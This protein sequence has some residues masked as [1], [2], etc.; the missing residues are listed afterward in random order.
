[1]TCRGKWQAGGRLTYSPEKTRGTQ[2]DSFFVE[3][4]ISSIKD[5]GIPGNQFYIRETNCYEDFSD[6]GFVEMALRTGAVLENLGALVA[7]LPPDRVLW[8]DVPDGVWYNRIPYLWP[9]NAPDSCLLNIAKFKSHSMGMTLSAK[10]IQG[11]NAARYIQHCAALTST[12]TVDPAHIQPGAAGSIEANYQ[13]HLHQGFPRWDTPGSGQSGGLWMETWATRCLDNH[14][15][16]KPWINI[17]EGVYGREG[18]FLQGPSADGYGIDVM[19]NL[20]IFGKNPFHAD[21]IGTWLAGHEPG[22]FGLFHMARERGFSKFLNPADVPLYEW[23]DDGTA[24]LSPLSSFARTPIRT[25]YLSRAGE[26]T[27]HLVNEPYEYPTDVTPDRPDAPAAFVL[28]Q[29]YPNPFNPSTSIQYQIPRGANVRLEVFDLCGQVV[30]RLVDGWVPAGRHLAV[31]HTARQ[32]SGTYF[33]NLTTA[34]YSA[35]KFMVVLK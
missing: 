6:G 28:S 23:N 12:L 33:Y 18:P 30:A 34:G 11:T 22:N 35:T 4:L 15:I 1:M 26:D 27:W 25:L 10:N 14:S 29:N 31:W 8:R 20:V 16:T 21:V 2:T 24:M 13:R 19:C 5:L 3:G 17:I 32:P 7:Q 9:V